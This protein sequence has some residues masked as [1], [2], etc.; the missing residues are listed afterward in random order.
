MALPKF[1]TR[2]WEEVARA[3]AAPLNMMS[4]GTVQHIQEQVR[5]KTDFDVA[6]F[7]SRAVNMRKD[8]GLVVPDDVSEDQLKSVVDIFMV[9]AAEKGEIIQPE[10]V[11]LYSA[12]N[13]PATP[14]RFVQPRVPY[15]LFKP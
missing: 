10:K 4:A 1:L 7:D 11:I 8:V 12:D 5:A 2:I 15:R 3:F 9:A 13:P 6:C 14:S